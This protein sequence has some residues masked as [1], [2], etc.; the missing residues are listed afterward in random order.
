M[1]SFPAIQSRLLGILVPMENSRSVARSI[2]VLV[3]SLL[4]C[5]GAAAQSSSDVPDNPVPKDKSNPPVA[6]DSISKSPNQTQVY[7]PISG[8]KR[9]EW[10]FL[11][12]VGPNSL[13]TG[14]FTAGI[15]TARDK[16][17][18][19]GPH[20]YGF[21]KRYGMRLTGVATSNAMEAGLGSIWGED[22]RYFRAYGKPNAA[23]FRSV[24]VQ[25]FVARR[26]DGRF[27]PAYARYIAIPGNNFLS[28]TWRADSEANTN[29][30]LSRTGYGFL[31]RLTGNAYEEFWPDIK[32]KLLR[33]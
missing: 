10:F 14:L 31:A 13:L 32:N 1:N 3:L 9:I 2:S 6:S 23:R 25:T 22:P 15:G 11:E 4:V 30:A 28:N 16:P 29:S 7:D 19:Y 26:R 21:T 27:A 33:R 20:I 17:R 5:F 8:T 18:E 12:S 24:I